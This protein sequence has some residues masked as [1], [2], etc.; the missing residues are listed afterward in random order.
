MTTVRRA[1][2]LVD[3][4]Q[5][6][7]DGPLEIQYPPLADSLAQIGR[8]IDVAQDADLPIVVVQHR[9]GVGAP[10]FD[11]TGPRYALHPEIERR[12]TD[13]WLT[14]TKAFGSVFADTDLTP[15]LRERAIDTVTLVGYMTNN[16]IL[17]SA[18]DAAPHGLAAEVLS[19]ATGAIALSN[20][21]GT[22]SAEHLHTTLLTLLHSNFAAVAD[23]QSWITAVDAGTA[24]PKDNLVDSARHGRDRSRR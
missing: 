2:V 7:V 22:V 10:I 20:Q 21:A 3:V 13:T 15:W 11:P 1:L 6:Y 5:E 18:A 4:Q 23:T 8:A 24:L 19:D 16:C 12:R 14:L 17:A 9:S